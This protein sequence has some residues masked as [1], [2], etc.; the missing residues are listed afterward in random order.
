M[1]DLKLKELTNNLTA[2]IILGMLNSD[3]AYE[4]SER[5]RVYAQATRL[6]IQENLKIGCDDYSQLL[7]EVK[8]I[9]S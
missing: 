6:R 5:M 1:K 4:K 8:K 3:S 9:S 2:D 7:E